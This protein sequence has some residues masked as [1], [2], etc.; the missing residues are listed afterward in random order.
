M[1]ISQHR[2]SIWVD[3]RVLLGCALDEHRV[4]NG[5]TPPSVF[6]SRD[7]SDG[8]LNTSFRLH[9]VCIL[10][11]SISEFDVLY[12]IVVSEWLVLNVQMKRRKA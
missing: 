1:K 6:S 9:L 7:T 5:A 2:D 10:Y 12:A 4:P 3:G 8:M 11:Y